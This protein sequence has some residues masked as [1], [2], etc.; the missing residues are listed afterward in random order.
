M[1]QSEIVD[2]V[3]T[4]L[5]LSHT[6]DN[7]ETLPAVNNQPERSDN[8]NVPLS[9]EHSPAE[10]SER[11]MILNT[12]DNITT[13]YNSTMNQYHTN[14][15]S[16]LSILQNVERQHQ[17]PNN[18]AGNMT[19]L[20]TPLR[21]P[22]HTPLRTPLLIPTNVNRER[23][24]TVFY[25]TFI[26]ENLQN[27]VVRPS[28][29]EIDRS[30][31]ILRYTNE[32]ADSRCPITLEPFLIGDTISRIRHCGHTFSNAGLQNWFHSS[33][34]C[35]VCRYDIREYQPTPSSLNDNIEEESSETNNN[36][37][38]ENTDE[39]ELVDNALRTL[40]DDVS[41]IITDYFRYDISMNPNGYNLNSIFRDNNMQPQVSV[42]YHTQIIDDDSDD[43]DDIQPNFSVD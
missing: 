27:V 34:R 22:L 20:R 16:A 21:T 17:S 4:L 12:L 7:N 36:S 2:L 38:R 31:E 26:P 28:E 3:S 6:P 8:T 13:Q 32:V 30:I 35:P 5:N 41:N 29:D 39:N 11:Q 9:E 40:T 43:Y 18:I 15:Q 10:V 14:I 42:E 25:T 19:P 37:E 1:N 24:N 33:V 23:N